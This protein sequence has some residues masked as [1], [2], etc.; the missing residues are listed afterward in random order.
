MLLVFRFRHHLMNFATTIGLP[1]VG[2]ITEND[3]YRVETH[4][5]G[6]NVYHC[7]VSEEPVDKTKL[8]VPYDRFYVL[9][10]EKMNS[11]EQ[12]QKKL[13]IRLDVR[14]RNKIRTM[15]FNQQPDCGEVVEILGSFMNTVEGQFR[16]EVE[17]RRNSDLG[18]AIGT[19]IPEFDEEELQVYPSP[20]VEVRIT[21]RIRSDTC[22]VCMDKPSDV[23]FA[24]CGHESCCE[25]CAVKV[26]SC[27]L[28]RK[29]PK[30]LI[31]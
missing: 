2:H 22:V 30:T 26:D 29:K 27:P 15:I 5:H 13:G 10:S 8:P 6:N 21:K 25:E 9:G 31:K 16:D 4:Y 14:Q 11:V 28:C 12:L 3:N 18:L 23:T 17:R 20:K 1:I 24:E 19:Q 7:V